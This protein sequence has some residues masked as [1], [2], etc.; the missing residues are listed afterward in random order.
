MQTGSPWLQTRSPWLLTKSEIVSSITCRGYKPFWFGIKCTMCK[1]VK[2]V[3]SNSFGS[4]DCSLP[5]SSVLG[6]LRQEYWSGLPCLT[7]GHLFNPGIEPS[8]F[9]S[10]SLTS[11]L[12]TTSATWEDQ[13]ALNFTLISIPILRKPESKETHVPQCSS[14]HC[15]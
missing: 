6:I 10:P 5:G 7:P 4:Y 11:G 15:L 2:S 9:M 1:Y 3:Q 8:S 14:Q 13:N 12:F